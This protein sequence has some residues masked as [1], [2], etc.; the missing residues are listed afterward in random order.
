MCEKRVIRGSNSQP[1]GHDP[2]GKSLYLQNI[3]IMISNCI[4]ITVTKEQ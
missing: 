1:V 2:L 4:K 3:Y